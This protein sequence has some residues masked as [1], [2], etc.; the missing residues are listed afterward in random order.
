MKLP[1]NVQNI[2]TGKS[3]SSMKQ[4]KLAAL[5]VASTL[6]AMLL[7]H[8]CSPSTPAIDPVT[9]VAAS[10][11]TAQA[12]AHAARMSAN[13]RDITQAI[14]EENINREVVSKPCI[15]PENCDIDVSKGAEGYFADLVKSHSRDY[16]NFSL[17]SDKKNTAAKTEE[18]FL[19]GGH[20]IWSLIAFPEPP[21]GNLPFLFTK[22]LNITTE[23]LNNLASVNLVE[24]LDAE[25][26]PSL[27]A[28]YV[29]V[30]FRDSSVRVVAKND[31]QEFFVSCFD[32]D[33][34]RNAKVIGALK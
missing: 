29:V 18:Q 6:A 26:I 14:W 33:K 17:F 23:D 8:G 21:R 20:N 12:K 4:K 30:V 19:A 15:W 7:Q 22:N 34:N 32:N 5:V 10:V 1:T 16:F 28:D 11:A 31:L 24:K 9:P 2:I 13:G 25:A 27:G 3:M